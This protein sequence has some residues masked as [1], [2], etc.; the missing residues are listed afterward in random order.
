[1]AE[2][3]QTLA[4]DSYRATLLLRDR[5]CRS[6]VGRAYFAVY[7]RVAAMLTA[8]GLLMR[9]GREGPSHAKLP[10]LLE[11]HLA[12]LGDRRWRAA[13]LVRKLYSMRLIA[14]YQPSVIVN[15]GDVRNTLNM[16]MRAF[17]L[18]QEEP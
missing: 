16:M 18:L 9:A 6:A 14:D 8:S 2:N 4:E 1:M 17:H 15:D 11:T 13:G 7:S 5:H 3:W 12:H 10:A